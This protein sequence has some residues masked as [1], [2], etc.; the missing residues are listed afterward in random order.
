[1]ER[2]TGREN[3]RERRGQVRNEKDER[4]IY[5]A[6]YK[7]NRSDELLE[8]LLRKCNTSRNN[9][10]SLLTNGQVLVNGSVISQYDFALAKDDE[11]K[12]S[13]TPMK[14]KLVRNT[15]KSAVRPYRMDLKII[16]EDDDFVAVDKPVGL[17]SVESDKDRNC[18]FGKVLKYLQ[19]KDKN[20]RPFILHRIDKETS[21]VLV[22]AKNP[23]VYSA[24]KLKWNEY[25][26]E[27]EYFAIAE[28]I[29]EKKENRLVNY[30]KENKNNLVFVTQDPSGQK[31][32]TD[33][34]VVREKDGLSLLALNIQTGRKNQIRVQLKALGHSI[35]GDEKYGF[36]KN[37]L[38]RLGLHA[39][40]LVFLHPF[41]KELITISASVPNEFWK[42]F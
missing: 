11:V 26:S 39:S 17:L 19:S 18:A 14:D 32:V 37:P 22:F 4:I 9:V 8:F 34:R 29:F 40:K 30:L 38:S 13:K 16:Y 31:A 1:M 27:R 2:R 42:I 33:Y 24:L 20:A 25:V 21:G 12:I 7:V 6:S 36:T 3:N 5:T 23:K 15:K 35:V 41:T 28:G 10:K